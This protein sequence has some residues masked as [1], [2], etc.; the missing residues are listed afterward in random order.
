MKAIVYTKYGP[1]DVLHLEEVE[2]PAPNTPGSTPF[3][4]L[5]SVSTA[6]RVKNLTG[7]YL[8]ARLLFPSK[9]AIN[10][11]NNTLGI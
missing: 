8:S 2:K 4:H 3:R 7:W 6:H 5:K 11:S 10:P 1:P 9:S